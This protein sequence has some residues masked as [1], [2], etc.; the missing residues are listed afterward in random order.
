MTSEHI[1]TTKEVAHRWAELCSLG[2]FLQAIDELYAPN[3]VSVEPNGTPIARVE[4]LENVRNKSVRFAES[5]EEVFE[6]HIS[7]PDVAGSFFTCVMSIELKYKEQ[8]RATM[9]EVCVY[10]VKDGKIVYEQFFY[11]MSEE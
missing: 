9:E 4:G 8:A 5:V 2:Q 10:E 11:D 1:R 7:H 3:V 6:I